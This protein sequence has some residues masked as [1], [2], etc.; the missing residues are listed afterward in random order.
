[1]L[2]HATHVPVLCVPPGGSVASR[3]RTKIRM[4]LSC[5][6]SLEPNASSSESREPKPWLIVGLGN[7]GKKY[8]GTRHNVG[9]EMID[10][11]A[12]AEGISFS[13]IQSKALVGKGYIGN[14]PV[15][16]AKPQTFMNLSGEAVG[17][18]LVHYKIAFRHTLL[19][20]DTMELPCGVLNLRPK[21]G[22]KRHMGVLSI[23]EA[24]KGNRNMPKLNIGIG[25]PPGTMDPKAFVLQRFAD[26][27]RVKVDNCLEEGVKAVR[28]LLLEGFSE[29]IEKFNRIQKYMNLRV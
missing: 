8:E 27:E 14:T 6:C 20:Y 4:Q 3:C 15:L 28:M 1:M 9:F 13:G 18:L 22:H 2:A 7:P 12:Q 17:P 25:S 16:L 10:S 26:S 29:N 11:I 19:M 23:I 5:S 24:L 21:G